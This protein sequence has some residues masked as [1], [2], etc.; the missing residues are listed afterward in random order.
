MFVGTLREQ[1]RAHFMRKQF[2]RR[3]EIHIDYNT[4]KIPHKLQG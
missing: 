4:E 2:Q 3:T 1:F